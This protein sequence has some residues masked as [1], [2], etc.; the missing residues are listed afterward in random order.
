[1]V[2]AKGDLIIELLSKQWP[3]AKCELVS[4]NNYTF[5]IA[6]LLSAQSTDKAVNK[7]TVDLFK[8]LKTPEDALKLGVS[9]IIKYIKSIGLYNIK[10]R[11]IVTLSKILI[12]KY[13]G[14]VPLDRKHLELLPGIGRKSAN[15]IL[16]QLAN[17]PYI[18]VDTH[19][20]RVSLRL[21]LTK[22]TDIENVE[23]DLYSVLSRKNYLKASNLLIMHGRY[24]CKARNPQCHTCVISHLCFHKK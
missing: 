4:I 12:D 13:N 11:N 7:A 16:N 14:E 22:N 6:V 2:N 1:M 8:V 24:T 21:N 15:V 17:L 20:K 9:G 10:A 5:V 23:S 19:V 3:N 18:A